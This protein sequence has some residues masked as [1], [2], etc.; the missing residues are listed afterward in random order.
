[1]TEQKAKV[2]C[3]IPESERLRQHPGDRFSGPQHR[4]N[5]DEVAETLKEEFEAGQSGH[6]QET[7]YKHGPTTIAL[8]LFGHLTRL[9]PHRA[10]GVVTIHVLEGHLQVAAEGQVHDLHARQLLV[11]APGVEH[12][13]VAMAESRMLLTVHLDACAAN[14]SVR[15]VVP[16]QSTTEQNVCAAPPTNKP[17]EEGTA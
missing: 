12:G 16:A 1:M 8:F 5:L 11:L 10:E 14:P 6:R 15:G 13:V 4:Y 17:S 3:E 9:P 2:I 7:L